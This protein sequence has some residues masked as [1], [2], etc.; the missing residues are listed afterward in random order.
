MSWVPHLFRLIGYNKSQIQVFVK[1]LGST[2]T[3]NFLLYLSE[4]IN[5]SN[6]LD[7]TFISI[8]L[9]YMGPKM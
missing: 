3:S 4:K 2:P 7:S 9:L 1:N 5:I 8:T 6:E